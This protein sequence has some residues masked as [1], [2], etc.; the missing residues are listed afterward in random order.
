MSTPLRHARD[1]APAAEDAGRVRELI[2]PA[3]DLLLGARCA[4]CGGAALLLCRGCGTAMRPQPAVATLD[5]AT[6]VPVVAAGTNA[7]VLRRV[8]VAWKEHGA[9]R[10]TSVLDHHLAAAIVPHVAPGRAVVLVPVPTSRRS[11]RRRGTDLVDELARSAARR[12]RRTGVDVVVE[13]A[14]TPARQT[15]DQAGLGA[16]ARWHNLEGAFRARAAAATRG[17]DIVVVDDIVTTGATL[18]EAVRALRSAGR[19]PL[20][21]AV[22]AS[23]PRHS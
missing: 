19:E 18:T 1:R 15:D 21:G 13:Q 12:L 14:L 4:G 9:T 7:D 3:A 2:V 5:G 8:L 23:T 11:R 10:L 20:G 17:R 22:V 16:R 6:G